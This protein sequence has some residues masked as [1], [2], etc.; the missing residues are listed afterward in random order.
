MHLP[1]KYEELRQTID[2]YI[3]FYNTKRL[4]KNLK[5]LTPIEYRNQILAS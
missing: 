3:I 4:Q 5:D 1:L 2:E